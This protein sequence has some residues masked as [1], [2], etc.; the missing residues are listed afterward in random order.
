[1]LLVYISLFGQV[2]LAMQKQFK[3][4]PEQ[5]LSQRYAPKRHDI[6]Y[7]QIIIFKLF[8]SKVYTLVNLF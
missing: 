4:A 6:L 3:E 5:K 2:L 7:L 8:N 1:M